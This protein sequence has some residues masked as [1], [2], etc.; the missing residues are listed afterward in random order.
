MSIF[1]K[2]RDNARSFSKI[3]R[4]L[5]VGGRTDATQIA[6]R[7]NRLQQVRRIHD[8][9]G[10]GTGTDDRVDFVDEQDRVRLLL[11][12]GEQH[13][14]AFFEVAA[15]FGSGQQRAEIERVDRAVGNDVRHLF[16]DNALGETFGNRGFAH[17]RL[18]DQQRIVLAPTAE[19]LDDAL[20][21]GLTSD[22]RIDA[23][24]ARVLIQVGGEGFERARLTR[25][26][27][28][29]VLF[30]LL[31]RLAAAFFSGTLEMPC[32]MKLTISMRA[33]FCCLRK[34]TA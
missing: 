29:V 22:Q 31:R 32:A 24:L 9:A 30:V 19:D 14:E 18:A 4:N 16:V 34:Y 12:V 33:T 27:A 26:A 6:R 15:V 5:L 28:V 21:F 10:R 8:A 13:L 3:P 25:F 1:W 11:Q 17:A 7:Q 23:A 2:R 20:D